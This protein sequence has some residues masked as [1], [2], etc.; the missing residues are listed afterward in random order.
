[1]AHQIPQ[2][3]RIEPASD[4]Q[5]RSLTQEETLEL[6]SCVEKIL[7]ETGWGEVTITL[8]NYEIYEIDVVV[9]NRFRSKRSVNGCNNKPIGLTEIQ[10]PGR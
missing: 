9:R 8:Q 7:G 4:L 10:N 6:K 5:G 3:Q 2:I 1:M